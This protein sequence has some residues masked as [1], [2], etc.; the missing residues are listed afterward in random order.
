MDGGELELFERTLRGAVEGA[1]RDGSLDGVLVEVG[2]HDAL[3]DDPRAAVSVLFELQG[4]AN[5]TSSALDAVVTGG[6]GAVV[7]PPIGRERPASAVDGD[8]VEVTGIG[9]AAMAAAETAVVVAGP[10]L[11]AVVK[12]ADLSL[13]PVEGLDP[14]LGLVEVTGTATVLEAGRPDESLGRLA[15]GHELVGASREMLALAR[16][17]ALEREQ[18]GRP[19]SQ[20][21][22][23]RHRLAEALVAVET[24][25]A[26][27]AAAWDD[28]SAATAAMAKAL[29]GRG[30]RTATRHCQQVLAGI[31]FTT[32]H[33]FHHY[34]RRVLV[35]DQLLGSSASL[36][37]ELGADLLRTR[38]LP[39]PLPL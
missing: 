10:G 35:L 39:P 11:A 21:Q 2:W 26:A 29:A 8:R 31:G 28:R 33:P 27:L 36:T 22:A 7:L 19:I 25:A 23:V 34:V 3:A 32:E 20:F 9:T 12:A 17:H 15:L 14:L 5:A 6:G 38:R 16:D 37:R 18:F 13:R 30:A 24:A 1:G 4:R